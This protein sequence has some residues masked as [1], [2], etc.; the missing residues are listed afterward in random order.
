[1]GPLGGGLRLVDWTTGVDPRLPPAPRPRAPRREGFAFGSR[2]VTWPRPQSASAIMNRLVL[3]EY[4]T[5]ASY[6][7]LFGS[8]QIQMDWNGFIL[9][10][11]I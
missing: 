1:M 7:G 5:T 4:T 3:A 9:K 11:I 8:F 10:Q 6:K 2:L